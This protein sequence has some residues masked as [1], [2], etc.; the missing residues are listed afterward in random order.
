MTPL[1]Q[2]T[3]KI[4]VTK[5]EIAYNEN[6]TFATRFSTLFKNYFHLKN[7]FRFLT[8]WFKSC[9]LQNCC[10]LER[11]KRYKFLYTNSGMTLV[12]P[13]ARTLEC[14]HADAFWC[15][16]SGQ[17]MK[18]LFQKDKLLISFIEVNYIFNQMFL[19]MSAADLSYV[20]KSLNLFKF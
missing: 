3:F 19:M 12:M 5:G 10:M 8:R 20:G 14:S 4:I 2:T 11:V 6:F 9:M 1:Q 16:Y 15:L 7:V 17:I 13:L 18:T